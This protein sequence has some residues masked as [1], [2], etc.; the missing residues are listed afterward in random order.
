MGHSFFPKEQTIEIVELKQFSTKNNNAKLY[1]LILINNP[2][3]N[4]FE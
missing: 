1:P 4:D 2:R 3:K